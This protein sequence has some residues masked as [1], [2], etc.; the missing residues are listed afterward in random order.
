MTVIVYRD[1]VMAADSLLT[2]NGRVESYAD[3]I[4]CLNGWLVGI[5]GSW[6]VASELFDWFEAE[7]KDTIKRPPASIHVDDDKYPVNIMAVRKSDCAVYLIDGLGYPQ[8]VKGPFFALGSGGSI[9]VGALEMGAD[10]VAAV[11]AAIKHD[12]YCGG[13]VKALHV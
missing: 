4:R 11:K 6:G 8:K 9:A 5:S 12:C 3:K 1:G 2:S 10:A 7:C 13:K